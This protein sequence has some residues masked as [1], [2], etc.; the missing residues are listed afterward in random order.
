MITMKP[1]LEPEILEIFNK[2]RFGEDIEG[3]II[4]DGTG[5]L[6]HSL[7]RLDG[8]TAVVLD[9]SV[10][11]PSLLDGAIRAAIAVAENAGATGFWVEDTTPEMTKWRT[12][13][14][15]EAQAPIPLETI[16]SPCCG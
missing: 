1:I 11:D 6:G 8:T 7:W 5:C 14:C 4:S 2:G 3:L 12:V 10:K 13:F 9:V 15:K 16:F